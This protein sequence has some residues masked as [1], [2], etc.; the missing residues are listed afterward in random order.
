MSYTNR[1]YICAEQIYNKS[2]NMSSNNIKKIIIFDDNESNNQKIKEI[3]LK[4]R[5]LDIEFIHENSIKYLSDCIK[6]L[7]DE[8]QM[9]Q[10]IIFTIENEIIRVKDLDLKNINLNIE[11]IEDL[12]VSN[13]DLY[14]IKKNIKNKIN[15]RMVILPK[16]INS[17]TDLFQKKLIFDFDNDFIKSANQEYK[18]IVE[19]FI[20]YINDQYN[21]IKN[22][23]LSIKKYKEVINN[24]LNNIE[25]IN[26]DNIKIRKNILIILKPLIECFI[27]NIITLII[28]LDN[29][30]NINIDNEKFL[31]DCLFNLIQSIKQN[32]LIN[33]NFYIKFL[34]TLNNINNLNEDQLIDINNNSCV[35]N[36][37]PLTKSLK[38][39]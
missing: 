29:D 8:N 2:S 37:H 21:K 25:N 9:I 22:L 7:E 13:I 1:N 14:S 4:G 33:K 36:Y 32:N 15:N 38:Y 18:D 12:L 19:R 28:F 11:N 10:N 20:H 6:S 16:Y 30:N 39:L 34:Q 27:I 23:N 17:C 26:F 31:I 35:L 3:I 24:K 5:M